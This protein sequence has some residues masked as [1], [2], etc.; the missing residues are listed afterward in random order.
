MK[1]LNK[2]QGLE[3]LYSISE[4][5]TTLAKL[6]V[7]NELNLS[8]LGIL[9]DLENILDKGRFLSGVKVTEEEN[10]KFRKV[11]KNMDD[12]RAVIRH[13]LDERDKEEVVEFMKERGRIATN[14]FYI[15]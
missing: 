4:A 5:A 11:V 8:K 9:M 12:L 6:N 2:N 13:M 1:D 7:E 14:Q 3:V 10:N 15:S